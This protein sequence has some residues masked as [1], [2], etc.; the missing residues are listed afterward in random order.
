MYSKEQ[1]IREIK[2]IA[3]KLGVQSLKAKDFE[4]NSTIPLSTLKYYLGSWS[5]ALKEA[6][7]GPPGSHESKIKLDKGDSSELLQDLIRLYEKHGETPTLA[8]IKSEGKYTEKLYTSKWKSVNDAFTVA[9]Q[10]YLKKEKSGEI[11]QKITE[12]AEE[13]MENL[14]T[15]EKMDARHLADVPEHEEAAESLDREKTEEIQ[16]RAAVIE[17]PIDFNAMISEIEN[18]EKE[19]AKIA[20]AET[21]KD[22]DKR[23]KVAEKPAKSKDEEIIDDEMDPNEI[24][25][26]QA[27]IDIPIKKKPDVEGKEEK[28]NLIADDDVDF[29]DIGLDEVAIK[30]E[31]AKRKDKIEDKKEDKK[32]VKKEIKKEEIKKEEIKKEEI[33]K[34]VKV[35]K[36]V[37]IDEDDDK[38]KEIKIEDVIKDIDDKGITHI[39][40]TIQPKASKKKRKEVGEPINFR[41]LRYAPLNEEGVLYLFGL[42][43]HELGFLMESIKPGFPAGEGKR[44][45]DKENNRWEHVYIDFEYK[46]SQFEEKRYNEDDCDLVVCWIH[47]WEECP[48]EILELRTTIKYL[49]G[50]KE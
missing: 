14:L 22:G 23:K 9:K 6:D 19:L 48:V 3:E 20:E 2:R 16:K 50:F 34:E 10:K 18:E 5:Q 26:V 7:L 42:I 36:K 24:T 8:L 45:F 27:V 33:K 40:R 37:S 1:I 15:E 4:I 25:K 21:K 29:S 44:C 49:T 13:S 17:D 39:P 30:P 31:P 35:E 46:S 12:K 43:S 38:T 47:D 11:D 41:G 32:E 28:R